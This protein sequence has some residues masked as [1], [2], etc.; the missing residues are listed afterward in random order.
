MT[1]ILDYTGQDVTRSP[2]ALRGVAMASF[3]GLWEIARLLLAPAFGALADAT[4]DGA[5]LMAA[6]AFG[7]VGLLAWG[8]LEWAL[9]SAT[10]E[11]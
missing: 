10:K 8:L 11:R 9:G 7:A 6:A 5:M 3:T 4:S 2:A 1:R